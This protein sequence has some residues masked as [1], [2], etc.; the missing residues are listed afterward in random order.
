MLLIVRNV[1]KI[2]LLCYFSYG[3][4]WFV[5]RIITFKYEG[6]DV[7]ALKKGVKTSNSKKFDWNIKTDPRRTSSLVVFQEQCSSGSGSCNGVC[8]SK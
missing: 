3:K 1:V 4:L 8:G 2:L 6:K 7:I 5:L